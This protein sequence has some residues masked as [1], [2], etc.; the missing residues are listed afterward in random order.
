MCASSAM[1]LA[2]CSDE[3]L[4][5]KKNYDNVS[6]EVYD[7][8]EGARSRVADIYNFCLP[9]GGTAADWKNCSTGQDDDQGKSTEEYAGFTVFVDPQNEMS[10]TAGTIVPDYF[11]VTSNNVQGN[12]YGRIRNINDCIAGIENGS[13]P[14]SQKAELLG[15]VYF[16]RAWCYYQLVK[17]YGGV[18]LVKE[19]LDCV[20][21]SFTPRSSAK[22]CIDFIVSDLD[23]SAEL[24]KSINWTSDNYGR[25][26]AGAALAL[27]GRVLVLWASPMFNRKNDKSRWTNA[28]N[29]MKADLETIKAGGYDLYKTG[30]NVN[31]SDFAAVFSTIGNCEA[32]FST[33]YNT[34]KGDIDTQKNNSWETIIR[35]KNAGGKGGKTASQMIVDMFP[36]MDGK[37]PATTS[38]YTNLESSPIKYDQKYPFMRRDPRFYR[39][40][41]FPGVRW[42][43]SGDATSGEAG[44]VNNPSYNQGTSYELWNYVWYTTTDDEGNAESGDSYGADNLMSNKRGIYVRKRTDDLDV[45]SSP[46]YAY[47]NTSKNGGFA[48]SAAPFIEIRYAGVLLNLAEAACGAEDMGYAVQLLQQIRERVGYTA[49]N[50]YGLQAGL[51]GNQAACM[52]AILYERQIELSYEGKRFDDLRRW[53]LYD[54]GANIGEINGA[55]D[56]WR[57]EGWGGNTCTWLGFKPLNEQR[58]ETIEFHTNGIGGTTYDSDPILKSGVLRPAAIDLRSDELY[59]D[60]ENLH[61]WYEENLVYK[62][63]R[64]DGRD[65]NYNY[66]NMHFFAK[67]YF[68]GFTVGTMG[69]NAGLPQT[70]GWEDSNNGGANGTFDPLSES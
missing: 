64:T 19:V 17:W 32:I 46:L 54:G 69:D 20:P 40:F 18:P 13:L 59:D 15:Q 67:Y 24:L 14:E 57:L 47:D 12:P 26:T 8:Y 48:Y 51:E 1:L 63:N 30:G 70:I 6:S 23:H 43:Y 25:I 35:P 28:Y 49:A 42:A 34:Q 22:E 66:L 55:P 10:A 44:D 9:N 45:N 65:V 29:T 31:G 7:N 5:D 61:D 33:L 52:S 50:N 11:R 3:F 62:V 4:Q 39:T 21:E 2:S 56:T 60:L 36:M 53:M 68:L 41:A 27:K 37:R 38:T 16:F 58:R